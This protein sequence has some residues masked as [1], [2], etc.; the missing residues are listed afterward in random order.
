MTKKEIAETF[1]SVAEKIEAGETL[2]E[3]DITAITT[4]T[5]KTNNFHLQSLAVGGSNTMSREAFDA[6]SQQQRSKFM[7]SGGRLID[8]PE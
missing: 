5:Q 6:M 3:S 2:I 7:Q 4:A 8:V 1:R